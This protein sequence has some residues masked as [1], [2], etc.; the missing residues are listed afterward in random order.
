MSMRSVPGE[1][2][3]PSGYAVFRVLDVSKLGIAGCRQDTIESYWRS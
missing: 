1:F 3:Q 2:Y